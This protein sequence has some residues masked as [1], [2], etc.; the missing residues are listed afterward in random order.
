MTRDVRLNRIGEIA[1][2]AADMARYAAAAGAADDPERILGPATGTFRALYEAVRAGDR[3][4]AGV[5]AL[6]VQD[7]CLT[8]CASTATSARASDDKVR[9]LAIILA[10]ARPRVPAVAAVLE[11]SRA[12]EMRRWG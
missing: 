10:W 9:F 6:A 11:V 3:R 2:P 1:L 7:L 8:L 5:A 12:Q 4:S